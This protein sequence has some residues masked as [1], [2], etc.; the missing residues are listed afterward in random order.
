MKKTVEIRAYNLKPGR[1][2]EFHRLVLEK[3]M[4][5]LKRWKVDVVDFGPS[6]HDGDSYYL[7]RAYQGLEDRQK[8][9]DAFYG[10]EEWRKGPRNAIV[11]LIENH[12]TVVVEMEEAVVDA[13]RRK[14]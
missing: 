2:E 8:S 12:T 14:T 11:G 13:L 3:S 1:R 5:M 10:S 4:P 6:L 7:I 9:Q